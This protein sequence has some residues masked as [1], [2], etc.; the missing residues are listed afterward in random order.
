[1]LDLYNTLEELRYPEVAQINFEEF[2]DSILTG[3][4]RVELLNWILQ[5]KQDVLNKFK[6][7]TLEGIYR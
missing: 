1:M 6:E 4:K 5:D 7:P 2:E 3:S